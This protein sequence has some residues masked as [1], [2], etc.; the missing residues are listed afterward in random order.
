MMR[1]SR[2]PISKPRKK[3]FLSF[4]A[5][6]GW[7]T[8]D[9]CE[10]SPRFCIWQKRKLKLSVVSGLIWK[11]EQER[12][13]TATSSSECA[14]CFCLVCLQFW[15]DSWLKDAVDYETQIQT[16]K[17]KG[18][19]LSHSYLGWDPSTKCEL[20]VPRQKLVTS[21]HVQASLSQ[22]TRT[23]ST[24]ILMIQTSGYLRVGFGNRGLT[25]GFGAMLLSG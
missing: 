5:L 7:P 6:D 4:K 9:Q 14:H 2:V 11:L 20:S 10:R 25:S 15:A 21:V 22:R 16:G 13:S 19:G 1:N 17:L 24:T 23:I 12:E 3:L 8:F 18:S